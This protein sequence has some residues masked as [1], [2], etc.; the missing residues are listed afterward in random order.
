MKEKPD[1]GEPWS[2][3]INW[4]EISTR[5][6]RDILYVASDMNEPYRSR[7]IECVNACAGLADPAKEIAEMRE[8]LKEAAAAINEARECVFG[9]VNSWRAVDVNLPKCKTALVKIEALNRWEE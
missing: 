2:E 5:D 9:E 1:Y 3:V 4:D 7:A 8:A 6:G